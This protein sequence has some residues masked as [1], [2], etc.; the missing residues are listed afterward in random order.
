MLRRRALTLSLAGALAGCAAALTDPPGRPIRAVDGDTLVLCQGAATPRCKG[1]TVRVAGVDTP[2]LN[3]AKCPAEKRMAEE[4]RVFTQRALNGAADV[5]IERRGRH[6]D[7]TVAV[8]RLDG[9]DLAA[10]LI[11]AGLG[12]P[13]D[14]RGK[15]RPWCG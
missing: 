13:Y 4:A 10:L 12:R 2:E 6:Y 8:V 11:E 14:G 3:G 1:E 5:A 7:R 15:R 9:A